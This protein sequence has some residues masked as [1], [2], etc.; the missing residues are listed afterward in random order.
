MVSLLVMTAT[1]TFSST[2]APFSVKE[3]D[4]VE[5]EVVQGDKGPQAKDVTIK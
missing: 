1:R 3:G 2:T 5:F 4:A